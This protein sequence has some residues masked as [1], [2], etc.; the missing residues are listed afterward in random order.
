VKRKRLKR[1]NEENLE[2]DISE[3]D[4]SRRLEEEE[5]E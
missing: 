4:I 5:E 1:N 2:K 3:I